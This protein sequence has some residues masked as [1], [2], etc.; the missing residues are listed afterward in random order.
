MKIED[1]IAL[2]FF[3][4][5]DE[6]HIRPDAENCRKCEVKPCIYVCPAN[7]YKYE[8]EA[9]EVKVEV[10]GCLECG[11]CQ[12]VCPH[13]LDWTYPEGRFGVQYRCG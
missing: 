9:N 1:K 12:L 8:K 6:P 7:L 5:A 10:S 13:E 2:N 4:S 11:S 3:R